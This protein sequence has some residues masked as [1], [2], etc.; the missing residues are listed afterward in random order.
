MTT[1]NPFGFF[2]AGG[3]GIIRG[4]TL[5]IDKSLVLDFLPAGLELGE[6]NVTVAGKHPV[7][8]L[9]SEMSNVRMSIPTLL[10][11]LNYHEHRVCVPFTYISKDSV[12][13]GT[14]GPYC[15]IP[16]VY[17]DSLW[18]DLGSLLFW[19]SLKEMAH[20]A[21]SAQRYMVSSGPGHNLTSLTWRIEAANGYLPVAGYPNFKL[22]RQMLSQPMISS[23]PVFLIHDFDKAWDFALV[24]PLWT[25]LQPEAVY[26]QGCEV[27]G[28][29]SAG[30]DSSPL[31]A[32]ELRVP[33]RLS[34][35]YP[36]LF[37]FRQPSLLG[38]SWY[39]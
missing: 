14:P 15:F 2:N 30:I 8:F 16:K 12:T 32:Y 3:N 29:E 37:S 10:S 27:G 36:P 13:P 18:A 9:F 6:Q 38:Q 25:V 28:S 1:S 7:L 20:F 24:R 17:L 19:G 4:V 22:V 35:P 11:P 31:G 39:S 33:W 26:V 5:P 21:V 34:T 23:G